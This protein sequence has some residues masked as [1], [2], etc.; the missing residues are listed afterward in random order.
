MSAYRTAL[1]HETRFFFL[2]S[3]VEHRGNCTRG[4]VV[5]STPNGVEHP[6]L[7]QEVLVQARRGDSVVGL[8]AEVEEFSYDRGGALG[9]G[10]YLMPNSDN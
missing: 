10:E 5:Y 4:V 7:Q 1:V 2:L 6:R 3:E 8:R 9:R